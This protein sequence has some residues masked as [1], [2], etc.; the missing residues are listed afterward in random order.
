MVVHYS[1]TG[2][3]NIAV[4]NMTERMQKVVLKNVGG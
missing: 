1:L 2:G 4:L 3:G